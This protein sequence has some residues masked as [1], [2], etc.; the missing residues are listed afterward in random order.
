MLLS[1]AQVPGGLHTGKARSIA[2][3]ASKSAN[4]TCPAPTGALNATE[5]CKP[6]HNPHTTVIKGPQTGA[7]HPPFLLSHISNCVVFV[8]GM[9]PS[10]QRSA[11]QSPSKSTQALLCG[12]RKLLN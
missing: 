5:N 8:P 6:L 11:T 10:A 9:R 1:S 3:S 12:E 2:P 7:A 4:A